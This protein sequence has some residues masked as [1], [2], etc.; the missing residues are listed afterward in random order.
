MMNRGFMGSEVFGGRVGRPVETVRPVFAVENRNL[1]LSGAGRRGM[2][3]SR[4]EGVEVE[5]SA[6]DLCS[7]LRSAL[8]A[9]SARAEGAEWNDFFSALD[10]LRPVMKEN[11]TWRAE[12]YHQLALQCPDDV[13]KLR[14]IPGAPK[15]ADKCVKVMT[16]HNENQDV[17]TK[18]APYQ[19]KGWSV[20]ELPATPRHRQVETPS[21]A[22]PEMKL[23]R[24]TEIWACPPGEQI[25]KKT[26][27]TAQEAADLAK[28]LDQA[29]G[30]IRNSDPSRDACVA[31]AKV[32]IVVTSRLLA[33]LKKAAASGDGV[34]VS[35]DEVDAANQVVNC[36]SKLGVKVV[37]V[38]QTIS[39]GISTGAA[40]GIVGSAG[41][42]AILLL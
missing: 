14:S 1:S 2:G 28:S 19:S 13:S 42:L 11:E 30:P 4:K 29:T 7:L 26:S 22:Y 33:R 21:G 37:P 39:P 12:V 38:P 8:T 40:A 27:L 15:P 17:A 41:A 25:P 35:Q 6:A 9:N 32:D 31:N 20:V 23:V 16:K 18:I 3:Q 36:A 5:P 24:E 34:E 10:R